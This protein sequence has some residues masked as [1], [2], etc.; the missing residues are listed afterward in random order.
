VRRALGPTIGGAFALLGWW[1][2]RRRTEVPPLADVITGHRRMPR[3][4]LS[5]DAALQVLL[6]GS[7]ASLGREGA[8]ANSPRRWAISA[9]TTPR[10]G[11]LR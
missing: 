3:L 9:R 11:R 8:P 1:I 6:V 10:A 5:I 7:G 2:L 4:P